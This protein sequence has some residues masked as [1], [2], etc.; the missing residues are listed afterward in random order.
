M[1]A[2]SFKASSFSKESPGVTSRKIGDDYFF[3]NQDKSL[4]II[5]VQ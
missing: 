1:K 2:G 5:Y 3:T 4:G